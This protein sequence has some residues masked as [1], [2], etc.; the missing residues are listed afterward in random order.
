MAV[1]LADWMY[2]WL[3]GS[4]IKIEKEKT[5]DD[6]NGCECGECCSRCS[7]AK[8]TSVEDTT[9]KNKDK[10]ELLEWLITYMKERN[11]LEMLVFLQ[12]AELLDHALELVC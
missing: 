9:D 5:Y 12:E 2:G 8:G 1:S 10:D 3:A 7:N 4:I 11:F 6:T